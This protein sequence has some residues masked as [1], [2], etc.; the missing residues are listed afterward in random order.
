VLNRPPGEKSNPALL[1]YAVSLAGRDGRKR[2]CFPPTATGDA[3][4]A[5]D[6]V[7][8]VFAG[9]QDVE[10]TVLTLFTQPSVP[11]VRSHLTAQDVPG[12][13]G[14]AFSRRRLP[15]P[16]GRAQPALTAGEP[17]P[18]GQGHAMPGPV[19]VTLPVA[20]LTRT[21]THTNAS[22]RSG[23]GDVQPA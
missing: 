20:S 6:A 19:Q 4:A 21:C 17:A 13:V 15:R 14:G 23:G 3:P 10:F 1:E 18:P 7:T 22:Y 5:I 2:V 16:A 9:R 12:L 11:D 8:E